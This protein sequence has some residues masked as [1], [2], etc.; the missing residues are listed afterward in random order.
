MY[1]FFS[2]TQYFYNNLTMNKLKPDK[3]ESSAN[4]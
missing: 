3:W 2:L 4:Q 1:N